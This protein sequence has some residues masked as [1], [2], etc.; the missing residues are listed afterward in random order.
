MT[1][2]DCGTNITRGCGKVIHYHRCFLY[3]PWNHCKEFGHETIAKN[4][5]TGSIKWISLP[6][7]NHDAKLRCSLYADD[8]AIFIKPIREDAQQMSQILNTFSHASSLV[9]TMPNAPYTLFIVM[10]SIWIW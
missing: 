9:T 5:G 8:A 10:T 3:W 1:Q 6:I 7:G 4:V 2:E